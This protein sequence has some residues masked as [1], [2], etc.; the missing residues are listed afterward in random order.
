MSKVYDPEQ[1]QPLERVSVRDRR[2]ADRR[3]DD[4]RRQQMS[5]DFEARRAERRLLRRRIEDQLAE[6]DQEM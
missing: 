1:T 3:G 4:R 5:M 6:L 2:R